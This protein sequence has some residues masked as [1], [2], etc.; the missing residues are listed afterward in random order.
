[1]NTSA[2]VD[3]AL[4]VSEQERSIED[5]SPVVKKALEKHKAEQ[6]E[7]ASNSIVELLRTIENYKVTTRRDIRRLKSQLKKMTSCLNQ[8]DHCWDYAQKTSNFLPV[9]AFLGKLN[10]HDLPNPEDYDKLTQVPENFG[11]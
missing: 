10:K 9:L 5:V 1:M 3:L 11:D 4:A 8:L 6:E 2:L 7:A